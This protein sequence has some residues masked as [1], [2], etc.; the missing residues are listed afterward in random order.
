M[1]DKLGKIGIFNSFGLDMPMVIVVES[2]GTIDQCLGRS[3]SNAFTMDIL[4]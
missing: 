4:K 2:R 1:N 3:D